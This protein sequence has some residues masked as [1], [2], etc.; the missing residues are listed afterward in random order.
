VLANELLRR[1]AAR[2]GATVA[3]L[4]RIFWVFPFLYL[5]K[6]DE[7]VLK[8]VQIVQFTLTLAGF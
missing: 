7:I 3:H 1:L 6:P 2:Y 5:L 8:G 4:R